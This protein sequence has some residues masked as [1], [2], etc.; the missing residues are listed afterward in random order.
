MKILLIGRYGEGEIVAGPERVARELYCE[1][2]N[3][4]HQV[5]F[6]EYFFSGYKNSSFHKKL[7]GFE[8]SN[9]S[10]YTL[11]IVPL[12]RKL[13]KEKFEIIHIINSQRFIL[14]LF[15][16][17]WIIKSKLVATLHGFIRYEIP[18][19]KFWKKKYFLDLLVEKFIVFKCDLIVFPS[20]LLCATFT[21]YYKISK[22]IYKIIPNGVSDIYFNNTSIIPKIKHSIKLIFYNGF[23]GAINKGID[24][25]LM[26]LSNINFKIE[27]YIL[28]KRSV[29]NASNNVEVNFVGMMDHPDLINFYR[30]KH[31]V[32]KSP[33]FEPFSIFVAECMSVGLIPILN[34]NVGISDFIEHEVNGFIYQ[35]KSQSTFTDL[36]ERILS[37]KY[38]LDLIST[39]AKKIQEQLNWKSVTSKYTSEYEVV[40]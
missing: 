11:G 3:Q 29:I 26:L 39:N 15:L 2:K 32:I 21:N 33:A 1:L 19:S 16:V 23:T 5:V 12:V 25:L 40:V 20:N 31:F 17:R 30:D 7:F 37:N 36:F 13:V 18:E 38:D 24:E 6:F 10:I 4:N 34:E 27:I 9:N 28:G 14:V 8:V 35:S 22:D